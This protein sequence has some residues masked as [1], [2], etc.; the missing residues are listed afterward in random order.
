MRERESERVKN[1]L[2]EWEGKVGQK[3]NIRYK[4]K[5]KFKDKEE[6][7]LVYEGGKKMLPFNTDGKSLSLVCIM[8]GIYAS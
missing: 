2:R 1:E 4:Q 8:G 5:Q 6:R 3:N 7:N